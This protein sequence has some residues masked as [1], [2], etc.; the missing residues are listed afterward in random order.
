MVKNH[1]RS[2]KHAQAKEKLRLKEAREHDI[3]TALKVRN[4]TDHLVGG[5]LA[6]EQQVFRVK[7]VTVFLK[8]LCLYARYVISETFLRKEDTASVTDTPCPT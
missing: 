7:G 1:I 6:E 5:K 8:L 2:T 3:A 4:S